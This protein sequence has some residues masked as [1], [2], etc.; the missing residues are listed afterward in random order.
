MAEQGQVIGKA[1]TK[2]ANIELPSGVTPEQF[3][4]IV[5]D[6]AYML[7]HGASCAGQ[8]SLA[9]RCIVVEEW[10]REV[11]KARRSVIKI[12]QMAEI[13]LLCVVLAIAALLNLMDCPPYTLLFYFHAFCLWVCGAGVGICGSVVARELLA[14]SYRWQ[15][16]EL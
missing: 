9:K 15:A 4:R 12:I 6:G 10:T 8:P 3:L 16:K 13:A 2:R 1:E 5:R 11:K 7:R 14:V